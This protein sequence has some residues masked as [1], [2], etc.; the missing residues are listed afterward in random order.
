M[1][2]VWRLNPLDGTRGSPLV[3]VAPGWQVDRKR[4]DFIVSRPFGFHPR[5]QSCWVWGGACIDA[6]REISVVRSE[7]R[8]PNY[9]NQASPF[10]RL[11]APRYVVR[12]PVNFRYD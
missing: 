1:G 2:R 4:R 7:R 3:Q 6:W 12:G 10:C 8:T 11:V 5:F 9:L